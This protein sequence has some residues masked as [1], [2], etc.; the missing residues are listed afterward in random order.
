M[1]YLA[2]ST[3]NQ[4]IYTSAIISIASNLEFIKTFFDTVTKNLHQGRRPAEHFDHADAVFDVDMA[5]V[6]LFLEVFEKYL[7]ISDLSWERTFQ[8]MDQS[9][10]LRFIVF[11]K[12]VLLGAFFQA[13]QQDIK[14]P[15]LELALSVGAEVLGILNEINDEHPIVGKKYFQAREDQILN[16]QT[17]MSLI[18][19][20][21]ENEVN[22]QI[23]VLKKLP[24]CFA[25]E[26][27]YYLFLTILNSLRGHHMAEMVG[28]GHRG[29]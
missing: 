29:N 9:S 14:N 15:F 11:L 22:H 4:P 7:S 1:M 23:K 3:G 20:M 21:N 8:I 17:L 26:T 13:Q 16:L 2:N 24:F 12:N 19:E 25:F 6:T 5:A 28:F 18:G 10:L 27:K